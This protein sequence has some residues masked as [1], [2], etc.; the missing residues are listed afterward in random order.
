MDVLVN[1]Q[2]ALAAVQDLLLATAAGLL[3]CGAIDRRIGLFDQRALRV[4]RAALGLALALTAFGYLWLQAAVMSGSP[5]G[6]AEPAVVAVLTE[7]H[8]GVAWSIG[9][10]GALLVAAGIFAR[11]RDTVPC[12][13]GILLWAAGKAAMGHAADG[14]DFSWREAVHLTHVL[15]TAMWAGGVIA[16]TALLRCLGRTGAASV[17]AQQTAAFCSA[18]SH[19]ATGAFAVVLVTGLYNVLQDTAHTGAALFGIAWGRVLAAKLTCVAFAALLGGW[20]RLVVLPD[21]RLRAER[22]DTGYPAAQRRFDRALAVEAV[23]MVAVLAL[24]ALLGHTAPTAGA[25]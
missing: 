3:A 17:P 1:V 6:D 4:V 20:N 23:V 5:L 18:L 12:A 11:G 7:S 13:A 19:L 16:A 25:S 2:I 14:G 15:A 9:C 10:S 8:F 24:A 21:L 22:H